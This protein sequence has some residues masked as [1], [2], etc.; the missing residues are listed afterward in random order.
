MT[1]SLRRRRRPPRPRSPWSSPTAR[2]PR[3]RPCSSRRAATTCGCASPCSPAAAPACATSCSSTSAR[4]TAT[5][6]S[7]FDG[8]EVVVDRMSVPYLTGATIDFVDTHRAAGL[9]HR[10]PQ[11]AELLRLRRL[12]PLTVAS[13]RAA[14]GA[15]RARLAALPGGRIP[16]CRVLGSL[17][18]VAPGAARSSPPHPRGPPCRSPS[19]ARSPTDHLMHFPGRFAEQLLPDQLHKVSLSFL[20]D[21]LVV[22]RGGVGA[23]IAF[24]H[25]PARAA[26]G[27]GRRGRAPTSPTTGPGWSGTASTATRCTSARPRTPPGSSAPPTTTCARS[28]RSTPG[29]MAEARHDRAGPGRRAGRR[30]RPGADRADDP[31]GDGPAH[32]G[33][34]GA[35]LPVRRRPVPAAGPDGRRGHRDADRRRGVPVHQRLREGAAGVQDRL[36]RRRGARAGRHPGHHARRERGPDRVA[37]RGAGCTS[38]WCRRRARRRPD[39]RRRRLPGRLPR[40]DRPGAWAW[41]GP[42]RSA[43]CWPRW[44]WRPSAPRSTR[45]SRPTF[46]ARLAEAYGDDAAAEI[47]AHLPA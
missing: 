18:G 30:P 20:V 15:V 35:R 1:V 27:A 3:S 34:P 12:V 28:P 21:D 7:D 23:N 47:A 44:C 33:V 5:Q 10:Q 24:G 31:A 2:R 29:A 25:G 19:P 45:W 32:R 4:S 11:R 43:R 46:A 17:A 13:Q 14:P 37:G 26:P 16:A 9:H 8:V 40:R 39:R 6:V 36:E 38:R 42:R 22:R 41:S